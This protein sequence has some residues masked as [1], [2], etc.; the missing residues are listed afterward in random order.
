MKKVLLTHL[1][2]P[3]EKAL[4]EHLTP[5]LGVQLVAADKGVLPASFDRPDLDLIIAGAPV[6]A[7]GCPVLVL[8]FDRP[9]R[10]GDILRQVGRMLAQPVLYIGDVPFGG[11]IFRPQARVLAQ[12]GAADIALTDREVDIL[13]YL[14]R[15]S[16][17]PVSRDTL[18][19]NVWQY[20]EGVD[21]HTLETHI[22]RLRQKIEVSADEPQILR[23]VEG[24]YSLFLAPGG[25]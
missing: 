25:V 4:A 8:S 9:Q 12:E 10:L 2:P 24:G 15:H 16:A 13:A 11:R 3:I 18:L 22:Y 7:P 21:T 1:P 14:L 20:Q 5:A 19:K 17:A 23:T 6:A